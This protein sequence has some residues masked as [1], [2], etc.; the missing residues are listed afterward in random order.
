M[1][2][3]VGEKPRGG[4]PR[5]S[6]SPKLRRRDLILLHLREDV[7]LSAAEIAEQYGFTPRGVSKMIARARS[8]GVV[9]AD[10][11]GDE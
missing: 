8:Y 9:P 4:R 6:E 3:T 11:E 7:G 1:D 10:P 5:A 2:S